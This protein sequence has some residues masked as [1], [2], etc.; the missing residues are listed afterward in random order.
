MS[1]LG[2]QFKILSLPCAPLKGATLASDAALNKD[3]RCGYFLHVALSL[4]SLV[5]NWISAHDTHS[6]DSTWSVNMGC[7]TLHVTSWT[8][9]RMEKHFLSTV[10]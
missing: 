1:A 6:A 5:Q 3:Q 9:Q 10:A 2:H 4:L 7:Q 8:W